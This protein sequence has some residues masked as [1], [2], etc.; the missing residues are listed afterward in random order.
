MKKLSLVLGLL[1][2]A[3]SALA[4]A[5]LTTCPVDFPG[6]GDI[7][8]DVTATTSSGEYL[9]RETS[10]P[11]GY[12]QVTSGEFVGGGFQDTK[13]TFNIHCGE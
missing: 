3:G 10:C 1:M 7:P 9:V 11:P 6:V 12:D 4:D 2:L 13:G 8:A 5:E